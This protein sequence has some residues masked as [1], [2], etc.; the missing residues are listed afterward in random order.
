MTREIALL[1]NPTAGRGR[2]ARLL[3]PVADRLRR[4]GV[5]V[6][7]VVGR[8][9]D[10]A[11]DRLRDRVAAGVDGVVALGGDGL[12]NIALQV[13]GGTDLPL[14]IVPAG[15]GNDIGRALGLVPGDAQAATDLVRLGH[16]KA[17]DVARAN[18]R[19]FAGVLGSGFDSMVNERANRMTWP[20]GRSRYNVAIVAELR[21]FS[22]VPY[23]LELDGEPWET[24][25]M[26]VAV[27]NGPSYGGGMLVCPD[28]R[29]DDGLLDV[30]VLGPISKPE[31]LRV[32]PTVYKGTHVNHPAVTVR[33]A[34]SVALSATGVTAYADGERVSVL[35]VSCET[36][37]A[38]L[39][40][41]APDTG[42][43]ITGP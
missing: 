7:V 11:F 40:V 39:V 22:P 17:V 42:G 34:R 31:F 14:G 3:D 37:P 35:P 5:A 41:Y 38:G 18:G 15:T 1:V 2:G 27:G 12:V 4:D 28:A 24:E 36:V 6:D 33:R 20:R 13:V 16:T 29:L 32:F 30:T 43:E 8:D 9:G 26:L 21:T 25:A 10:E 19:W 23:V